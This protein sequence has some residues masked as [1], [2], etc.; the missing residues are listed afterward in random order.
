MLLIMLFAALY[1]GGQY[2]SVFG[3]LLMKS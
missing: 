3:L 2:A 1:E